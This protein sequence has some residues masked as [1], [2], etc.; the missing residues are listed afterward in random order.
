MELDG[1]QHCDPIALDYNEMRTKFLNS[2]GLYVL[3]ISNLDVM[4][5]FAGV[6][7]LIDKTVQTRILESPSSAPF[8]GTFPQG[9]AF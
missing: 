7:A 9:K 8:G 4:H 6:C 1:S 3:R 5:K 2:Q